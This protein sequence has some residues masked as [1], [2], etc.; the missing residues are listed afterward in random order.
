MIQK[1]IL[2]MIRN[3]DFRTY[4]KMDPKMNYTEK[5]MPDFL[6]AAGMK[7]FVS[8]TGMREDAESGLKDYDKEKLENIFYASAAFMHMSESANIQLM[9]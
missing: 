8:Y 9:L 2:K 4:L 7:L 5:D 3:E 6:M 1:Y